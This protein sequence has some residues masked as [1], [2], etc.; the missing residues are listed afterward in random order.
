MSSTLIQTIA[1]NT[2]EKKILGVVLWP[3]KVEEVIIGNLVSKL[4]YSVKK[5]IG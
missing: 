5:Q 2:I 1:N 4:L 3:T